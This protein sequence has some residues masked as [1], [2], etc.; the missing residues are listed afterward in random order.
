MSQ[1]LTNMRDW[2]TDEVIDGL[3]NKSI[4]TRCRAAYELGRRKDTPSLKAI[5]SLEMLTK[6]DID[7]ERAVSYRIPTP[8]TQAQRDTY[9]ALLVQHFAAPEDLLST[10]FEN[11]N[12][13]MRCLALC[14]TVGL[15]RQGETLLRDVSQRNHWR[16]DPY[17]VH[18]LEICNADAIALFMESIYAVLEKSY[19]TSEF[20]VMLYRKN[21]LGIQVLILALNSGSPKRRENILQGLADCEAWFQDV[22]LLTAVLDCLFDPENKVVRCAIKLFEQARLPEAVPFLIPLFKRWDVTLYAQAALRAI[23]TPEALAALDKWWNRQ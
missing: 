5:L 19:W 6:E 21:R 12:E 11:G 22:Q 1:T 4:R 16:H 9:H 8:L 10:I 7:A 13:N 2:T 14:A 20:V 18:A 15:G 23:G 17:F 3:G